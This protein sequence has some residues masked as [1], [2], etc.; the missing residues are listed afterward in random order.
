MRRRERATPGLR[1]RAPSPF[2]RPALE[3]SA[4]RLLDPVL[5]LVG[6]V[7]RG[8]LEVMAALGVLTE[9]EVTGRERFVR[10]DVEES[11]IVRHGAIDLAGPSGCHQTLEPWDGFLVTSRLHVGD[12]AEPVQLIVPRESL[13][14]L[15]QQALGAS[16]RPQKQLN[17]PDV[18]QAVLAAPGPRP[19]SRGIETRLPCPFREARPGESRVDAGEVTPA[20][21]LVRIVPKRLPE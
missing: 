18:R 9:R 4:Q 2:R 1:P 10:E 3:P 11:H 8:Q 21:D 5:E 13:E 12:A 15:R 17:A 7:L 19:L 16:P 14:R 20:E 6:I